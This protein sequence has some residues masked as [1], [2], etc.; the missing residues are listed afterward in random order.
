M[1]SLILAL[2]VAA[3][4]GSASAQGST[5]IWGG[6]VRTSMTP[7]VPASAY[8]QA[9]EAVKW[10]TG[11]L[12]ASF[13][14][15]KASEVASAR[16]GPLAESIDGPISIV[17]GEYAKDSQSDYRWFFVAIKRGKVLWI[18]AKSGQPGEAYASC[19]GAGLTD[20]APQTGPTGP[21]D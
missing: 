1:R 8:G 16:H 11:D 13:R 9:K 2:A 7:T 18:A 14:D 10:D 4:A 6:G 5:T 15:V 3:V 21:D 19:K 20:S 12:N 17:C